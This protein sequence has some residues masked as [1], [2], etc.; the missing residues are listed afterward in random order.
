MLVRRLPQAGASLQHPGVG[1]ISGCQA[2]SV[3]A[4]GNAAAVVINLNVDRP[5]AQPV[6]LV[7]EIAIK[8][9]VEAS[10]RSTLSLI[11]SSPEAGM[12]VDAGCERVHRT[13]R[14][15]RHQPQ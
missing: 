2:W 5:N 11:S 1:R 7:A 10:A 14:K 9:N 15:Q 8:V 13:V 3:A 6:T 12:Q 4:S